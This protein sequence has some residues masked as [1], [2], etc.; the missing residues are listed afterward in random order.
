MYYIWRAWKLRGGLPADRPKSLPAHIFP[1]TIAVWYVRLAAYRRL[2]PVPKPALYGPW[3]RG[4]GLFIAW[5]LT[6]GT[7][8]PTEIAQ[9]AKA[10]GLAWIALEVT[11]ENATRVDALQVA[12]A[13]AGLDFGV[14]EV[15]DKLLGSS[16]IPQRAQFYLANVERGDALFRP[17]PLAV[18]RGV[19]TNFGGIETVA[20]AQAYIDAGYDC[21]PEAYVADNPQATIPA[22][23]WEAYWRGWHTSYPVVGVYHDFPLAKCGSGWNSIYLAEA[24]QDSDWAFIAPPTAADSPPA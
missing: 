4:R 7:F 15:C 3:R 17:S 9:K 6:N 10:H 20:K 24:M 11:P 22:Q 13:A 19:V 12:C 1:A 14:W 16:P 18:P 23:K 5:G 21:L 2:H 8:T